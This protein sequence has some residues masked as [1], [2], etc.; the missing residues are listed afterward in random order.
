MHYR[1]RP[2]ASAL[3]LAMAAFAALLSAYDRAE[4]SCPVARSHRLTSR[5][6]CARGSY[7]ALR[8]LLLWAASCAA[9]SP[10]APPVLAFAGR[11][12]GF[13]SLRGRLEPPA[14]VRGTAGFL[15]LA[16]RPV[17]LATA[18]A[19]EVPRRTVLVFELVAPCL[20]AWREVVDG[21]LRP[22]VLLAGPVRLT[23]RGALDSAGRRRCPWL[24]A[25]HESFPRSAVLLYVELSL[26]SVVG[27]SKANSSAMLRDLVPLLVTPDCR[28]E[29]QERAQ[30]GQ[31]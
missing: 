31:F 7:A 26:M 21:L 24:T 1:G 28:I 18:D 23:R 30:W 25:N 2:A 11:V 5:T 3:S 27:A 15:L 12:L 17:G 22:P 6:E 4:Y 29:P 20:P 13:A 10:P 14:A 8:N 19:L 16:A 9:K